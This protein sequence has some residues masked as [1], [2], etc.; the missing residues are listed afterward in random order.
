MCIFL[1]PEN[2]TSSNLSLLT[3]LVLIDVATLLLWS[4]CYQSLELEINRFFITFH[5]YG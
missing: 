3:G 4:Y 5:I 1:Q 2:L